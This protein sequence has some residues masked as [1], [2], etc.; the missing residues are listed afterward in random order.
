M[1][2]SRLQR[3][4]KEGDY[5]VS[6]SQLDETWSGSGGLRREDMEAAARAAREDLKQQLDAAVAEREKLQQACRDLAQAV[7]R[8]AQDLY[9][10]WIDVSRGDMNAA[11][12]RV[13]NARPD[14]DDHAPDER[15]NGTESGTQWFERTLDAEDADAQP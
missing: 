1:H 13:L 12:E 15:W 14:G 10:M 3:D 5:F 8:Q 9:A 6:W 2:A 11:R 7:K 4:G